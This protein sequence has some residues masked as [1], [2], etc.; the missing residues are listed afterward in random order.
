MRSPLAA[1]VLL[2]SLLAAITA[3]WVWQWSG[4]EGID[5]PGGM[6]DSVTAP[7]E[8]APR[9]GTQQADSALP[10]G[11]VAMRSLAPEV[12]KGKLADAPTAWLRVRDHASEQ[13]IVGAAVRRLQGGAEIAFTDAQGMAA[14]PLPEPEQLAIVQDGY[15]LRLVPTRPGTTEAEPQAVQLVRDAWSWRRRFHFVNADGGAVATAFVRLRPVGATAPTKSPV[16]AGDALLARAWSEH[17]MLAGRPVCADVAVQI[18]TW[19][20]DRVHQLA[21]GQEVRFVAPGEFGIEVA[22]L[23]GLVGAGTLRIAGEPARAADPVT[24]TLQA[25]SFVAGS[26]VDL[27]NGAPLVGATVIV[28]GGEPL[29]LLATTAA[30]GTFRLGPLAAGPRMLEVR[31]ADHEPLAFGPVQVP[32]EALRLPMKS[33]P[34]TAL[35]GRVRSRP[36]LAPL[37]GATVVWLAAGGAPT[38]ATTGANGEFTLAASGQ[39]DARLT[40]QAAGHVTL[41]ELVAVGGVFADYD[42]W[43]ADRGQRVQAGISAQLGGVVTDRGGRP[44]AGA[45]VRWLPRERSAPT[46]VPG[47][48]PLEGAVLDLPAV[49]TTGADGGF[50]IETTHFGSGTLTVDGETSTALTVD[51]I[52]G[53]TRSDLR[54][55]R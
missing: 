49:T 19:S 18:G 41:V 9:Q 53:Q 54:L 36:V 50:V 21:D 39:T 35:R 37:A 45:S 51:A 25:G 47:R 24:V 27:G 11:T 32:A 17:A 29:G 38:T 22:T 52:A 26:I 40:V 1:A 48:R 30:D 44:I 16:P 5:G 3:L 8:P 42:L 31:H 23:G 34:K 4:D 12:G 15:L 7:A 2:L 14:I 55:Q 43:P 28:Q 46:A 13:P 20:E 6:G 33:L 10:A